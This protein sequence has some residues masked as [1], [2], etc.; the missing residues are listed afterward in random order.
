MTIATLSDYASAA[1]QT[2]SFTQWTPSN[3]AASTFGEI[4]GPGAVGNTANGLVPVSG[5]SIFPSIVPFSP[6]AGYVA[7]ARYS[8]DGVGAL[9]IFLYDRLFH[10]GAYQFNSGATTTLTAQPS[11]S[12]RVPGGDHAGI[13]IFVEPVASGGGAGCNIKVDYTNQAGTSGRTT[14]T[15]SLSAGTIQGPQQY[16]L[17]L[18]AGDSGV[19]RIDAITV[20]G[21]A[22]STA[23]VYLLRPLFT[24]RAEASMPATVRPLDVLGMPRIYDTSALFLCAMKDGDSSVRPTLSLDLEIASL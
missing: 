11:F 22:T 8:V 2:V 9:R 14:G 24:W 17:P 13:R 21:G 19:Q 7:G 12:G 5:A 6:G 4:T 20:T 23:N 15:V 10:V 3:W 18:S 1:R 16:P